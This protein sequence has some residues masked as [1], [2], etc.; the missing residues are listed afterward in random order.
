MDS[1]ACSGTE[2]VYHNALNCMTLENAYSQAKVGEI[3]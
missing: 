3:D 1:E 2:Y